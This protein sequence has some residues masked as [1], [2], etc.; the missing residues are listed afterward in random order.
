MGDGRG[1][2]SFAVA[3]SSS[4]LMA[5][6]PPHQAEPSGK[7]KLKEAETAAAI[8]QHSSLVGSGGINIL[9]AALTGSSEVCSF[10]SSNSDTQCQKV[11]QQT[12]IP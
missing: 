6:T 7:P 11:K 8:D 3:S 4:C 10:D 9:R 12:V 1:D 2:I 5:H